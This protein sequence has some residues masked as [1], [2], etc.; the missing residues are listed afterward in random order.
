MSETPE[1]SSRVY[2]QADGLNWRPIPC[3]PLAERFERF[4]AK[5]NVIALD[6]VA[7]FLSPGLF[8]DVANGLP[9][10]MVSDGAWR[11]GA[12]LYP[13]YAGS[14][15]IVMSDKLTGTESLLYGL[16]GQIASDWRHSE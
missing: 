5:D 9:E 1:R 13:C 16:K 6:V 3:G 12:F 7:V 15:R 8:Y 11:V 14:V 10:R 4:L 2:T